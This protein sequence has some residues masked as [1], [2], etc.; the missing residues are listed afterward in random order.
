MNAARSLD[1][2]PRPAI[3]DVTAR[4]GQAGGHRDPGPRQL[5]RAQRLTHR[6]GIDRTR[7]ATP[8]LYHHRL[9]RIRSVR[10]CTRA[11]HDQNR[12]RNPA[13][14]RSNRGARIGAGDHVGGQRVGA[15]EAGGLRINHRPEVGAARLYPGRC[16]RQAGEGERVSA[17]GTG[18]VPRSGPD[19]ICQTNL[20]ALQPTCPPSFGG[21]WVSPHVKAS[22]ATEA[23][24]GPPRFCWCRSVLEKRKVR[25][26]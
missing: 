16:G 6:N 20:S 7:R 26:S 17:I 19:S 1:N 9:D 22:F 3:I 14:P 24:E 11:R 18:D 5:H 13:V 23:H 21:G 8:Q 15:G 4:H 10:L 12:R 2:D 25:A